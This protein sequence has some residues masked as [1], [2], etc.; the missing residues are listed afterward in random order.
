M[1]GAF[2]AVFF[3]RRTCDEEWEGMQAQLCDASPS[4]PYSPGPRYSSNTDHAWEE[5]P[6]ESNPACK[7]ARREHVQ[8]VLSAAI[9]N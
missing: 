6:R 2:Y 4:S 7:D 5:R 3:V 8:S 1:N 9:N